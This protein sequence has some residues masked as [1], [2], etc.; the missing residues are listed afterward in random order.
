MAALT[1][2]RQTPTRR[3]KDV[4]PVAL[5][6]G[7]I[8]YAG[9]GVCINSSTGY[10]VRASATTGLITRGIARDTV[11]NTT[12]AAGAKTV[13]V[14]A[15][16]ACLTNSGTNAITRSHIGQ[17]CY[18]VDDQTVC[19][20]DGASGKS[21]AGTISDLDSQGVWVELCSVD[22]T[23]LAAEISARSALGTAFDATNP[24]D[25]A[26]DATSSSPLV[27]HTI[28]VPGTASG[29]KSITLDAT[30]GR[31]RVLDAFFIK[32]GTTGGASDTV[33]LLNGTNAISN[34]L[35]LSSVA[36]GSIVRASSMAQAYAEIAAGGTLKATWVN[37]T[38]SCE[39]TLV[40]IGARTQA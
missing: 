29:S 2:F 6:A 38:A 37:T 19:N 18:W 5:G 21:V 32:A 3:P 8:V 14:E 1:D 22:G 10:G 26:D 33:Q 15:A 7:A 34:A 28:A 30:Y 23:A 4:F 24:T 12:G 27:V 36:A 40:V 9:G 13:A 11:D 31:I 20:S 17:P 25:Q 39:G 35:A 16:V